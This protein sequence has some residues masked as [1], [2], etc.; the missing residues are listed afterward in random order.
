[1]QGYFRRAEALKAMLDSSQKPKRA[2]GTYADIV[3]DY[4]ESHTLLA[5]VETF[6]LAVILTIDKGQCSLVEGVC[7]AL[8]TYKVL[9][10]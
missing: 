9:T 2:P 8:C 1:M 4:L 7:I 6:C 5:N 10:V 3:K